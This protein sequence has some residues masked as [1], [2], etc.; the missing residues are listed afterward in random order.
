MQ[1]ETPKVPKTMEEELKLLIEATNF[2]LSNTNGKSDPLRALHREGKLTFDFVLSETE[3][4]LIGQSSLS[5]GKR[6]AVRALFDTAVR[7]F[8][9]RQRDANKTTQTESDGI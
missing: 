9:E 1:E 6:A 7:Q 5:S 2:V 4:I 3:K 8:E